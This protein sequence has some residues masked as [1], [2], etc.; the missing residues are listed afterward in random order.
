MSYKT[1]TNKDVQTFLCL[2]AKDKVQRELDG[3]TRNES[4]PGVGA[5]GVQQTLGQE[6]LEIQLAKHQGPQQP[7]R[8][9]AE[10]MSERFDQPHGRE[11]ASERREGDDLDSATATS[12]NMYEDCKCVVTS[13]NFRFEAV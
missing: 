7:E 4:L 5:D 1:W 8:N 11:P 6:T 3:A 12:E 10:T 9:K 2:M 13:N